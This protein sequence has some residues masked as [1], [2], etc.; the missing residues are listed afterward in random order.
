ME[1]EKKFVNLYVSNNP[2]F[3]KILNSFI[4]LARNIFQFVVTF[5]FLFQILDFQRMLELLV[6]STEFWSSKLIYNS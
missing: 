4:T 5:R 2:N 6:F 1:I 3:Q